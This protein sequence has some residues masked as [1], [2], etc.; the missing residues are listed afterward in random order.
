MWGAR[1]GAYQLGH[2]TANKVKILTGAH[3]PDNSY[4]RE[5]RIAAASRWQ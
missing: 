5:Q 1:P 3:A 2:T 4:Q